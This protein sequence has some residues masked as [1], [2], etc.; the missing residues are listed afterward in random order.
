MILW[1]VGMGAQNSL[2]KAMLSSVIPAAKRSTG[3][4]LFYTVFGVAWFLGSAAMGFLY[5]RSLITLILFSIICQLGALP[6]FLWANAQ[7]AKS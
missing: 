5:D 2:L 6:T 3:F 7:A 4:G 1:G